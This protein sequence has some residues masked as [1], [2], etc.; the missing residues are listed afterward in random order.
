LYNHNDSL[1]F[2]RTVYGSSNNFTLDFVD[3]AAFGVGAGG[4]VGTVG[5]YGA[6]Q[7]IFGSGSSGGVV[8]SSPDSLLLFHDGS[9][10]FY[11]PT[12]GGTSGQVLTMVGTHSAHW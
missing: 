6:N 2:N 8:F 11:F 3:M 10:Y 12:K 4:T 7:S 9:N 5:I 1:T